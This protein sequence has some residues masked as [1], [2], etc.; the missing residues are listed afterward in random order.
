MYFIVR[1]LQP[2]EGCEAFVTSPQGKTLGH[3]LI[4]CE[5]DQFVL[6]TSAGQAATLISH[7]ERYVITEEVEFRDQTTAWQ[8]LLEL[9]CFLIKG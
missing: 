3:I 5:A 8:D 7:F 6:D 2:G 1:R 9:P 4:F